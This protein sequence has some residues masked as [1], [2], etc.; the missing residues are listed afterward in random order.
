[1]PGETLHL[2]AANPTL[3]GGP[4]LCARA[5]PVRRHRA[6]RTPTTPRRTR[7]THSPTR[8]DEW[9]VWCLGED[10]TGREVAM[11]LMVFPVETQAR[12]M[13]EWLRA[14]SVGVWPVR[15]RVGASGVG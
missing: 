1:M 11:V 4:P 7:A 13:A 14:G 10:E 6:A 15:L 2:L 3:F 8:V 12:A 5:F 9:A